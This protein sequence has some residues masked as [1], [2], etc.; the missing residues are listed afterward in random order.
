MIDKIKAYIDEVERFT[1]DKTEELE[2][3]RIR[4]LG[5]KEF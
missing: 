1:A 3:F 5:K 4:F 2:Q